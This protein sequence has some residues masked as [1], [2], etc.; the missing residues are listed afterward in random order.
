MVQQ[1]LAAVL[2][3]HMFGSG[4][5]AM[6][7]AGIPKDDPGIQKMYVEAIKW[8]MGLVN[9]DVTPRPAPAQSAA[10]RADAASK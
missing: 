10:L 4:T 2:N 5:E 3:D 9:A 8:A 1:Y 7:A 6:L